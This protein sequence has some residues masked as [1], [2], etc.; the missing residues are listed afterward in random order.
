MSQTNQPPE[1]ISFLKFGGLYHLE[2]PA[3]KFLN[4]SGSYTSLFPPPIFKSKNAP[5]SPPPIPPP[6]STP[7]K[8]KY[9]YSGVL[10]MTGQM[11]PFNSGQAIPIYSSGIFNFPRQTICGKTSSNVEHINVFSESPNI[12]TQDEL[13]H[14]C[15][16]LRTRIK[17]AIWAGRNETT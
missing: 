13:C 12:P 16:D 2:S 3:P 11:T 14:E 1:S 15:V 5:T 8:L 4:V 7:N 10:T 6:S 9:P 17:I